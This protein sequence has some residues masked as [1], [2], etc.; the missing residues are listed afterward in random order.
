[1]KFLNPSVPQFPQRTKHDSQASTIH[2]D[3]ANGVFRLSQRSHVPVVSSSVTDGHRVGLSSKSRG[4]MAE[5][6]MAVVL[7]TTEPGTV[8]GVRIPLSPPT[9]VKRSLRLLATAGAPYERHAKAV[10]RS[11]ERSERLGEGGQLATWQPPRSLVAYR[12]RLASVFQPA[13]PPDAGAELAE[14]LSHKLVARGTREM[15]LI[16]PP[17]RSWTL[18]GSSCWID[19]TRTLTPSPVSPCRIVTE[20]RGPHSIHSSNQSG[21]IRTTHAHM[22]LNGS[23]QPVRHSSS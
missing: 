2:N 16:R 17:V 10:H 1:M 4:E 12:E 13:S 20:R 21:C 19:V 3:E 6:S 14:F 7:K 8:P 23:C 5:W 15:W 11:R 9:F 22:H 18:G